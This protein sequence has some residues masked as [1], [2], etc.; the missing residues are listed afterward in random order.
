MSEGVR[1]R[2]EVK[3]VEEV[4]PEADENPQ[5]AVRRVLSLKPSL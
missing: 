3:V 1:R 2:K 4:V 5:G